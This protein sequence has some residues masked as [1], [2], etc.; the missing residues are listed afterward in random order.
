MIAK[1]S[2]GNSLYGALTYNQEKV[3][4]GEGKVLTT[5]IVC[6]PLDGIFNVT[7]CMHQFEDWM[8]SHHRTKNTVMHVSLNPHPDDRLTD[9]ELAAIGEE[10]MQKLGY[11]GQPYMIYKHEDIDRHHIHI[12]S[13]RV[14]SAGQKIDDSYEY[15]RSKKITREIEIKYGLHP[16]EG[17]D[18]PQEKWQF[19]PI[20]TNKGNLK[21]QI[22]NVIKPLLDMYD[23]HSLGE[24]RALLSLYNITIEEIR[25]QA[26]GKPF[27][28]LLYSALDENGNKYGPPLKSS[29]FGKVAG[30]DS[31]L[32]VMEE[33][34]KN[35][36]TKQAR[37]NSVR[38]CTRIDIAAGYSLNE[39]EFRANLKKQN[40]G[41]VLRRND[42]GRIYGVTFIDH[43]SRTVYNGSRLGKGYSANVFNDWL[44]K[45]VRPV[46]PFTDH[47]EEEGHDPVIPPLSRSGNGRDH[48]HGYSSS[49]EDTP[50]Y[51]YSRL[52]GNGPDAGYE[53]NSSGDMF[54]LFGP[55]GPPASDDLPLLHR[56][57]KKKRRTPG[58]QQ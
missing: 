12:V 3:D 17:N 16:A 57:K 5:N 50:G 14:N 15:E 25:G 28:G 41:I 38:L 1:I 56:K 26:K 48:S 52:Y 37:D 47:R 43:V 34:A 30:R 27:H 31:L 46:S 2:C 21:R 42:T 54:S 23:F 10:Y 24:Y 35:S 11:G 9:G 55:A 4:K 20:D 44:N 29:V 8:P 13:L 45:G 7:D 32:V 18:A 40:V 51:D 49:Q 6:Q 22:S 36:K 53:H 19:A 39:A 58:R 33:S